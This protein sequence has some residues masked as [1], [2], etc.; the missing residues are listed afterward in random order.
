MAIFIYILPCPN[1][2]VLIDDSS[3]STLH[4][5]CKLAHRQD[6]QHGLD[7]TQEERALGEP[8]RN[9]FPF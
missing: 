3:E 8:R 2:D 6:T 7:G 4:N 5:T 1:L 9:A